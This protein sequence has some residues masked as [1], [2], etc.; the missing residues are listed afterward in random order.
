MPAEATFPGA[1]GKIAFTT[2]RDGNNEIY[3][4]NSDGTGLARLTNN[5]ASDTLTVIEQFLAK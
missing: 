1:N 2:D 4:V 5:S 3:V